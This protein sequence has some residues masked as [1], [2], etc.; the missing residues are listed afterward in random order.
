[1]TYSAGQ[2][3]G[4]MPSRTGPTLLIVF[5]AL[6]MV[7]APIIA[8]FVAAG[9][10]LSQIDFN[11]I[12]TMETIPNPGTTSVL[13]P[14]TYS[15][16]PDSSGMPTDLTCTVMGP[17]GVA[18]PTDS[19]YGAIVTF[20]ATTAQAYSVE[21]S[22]GSTISVMDGSFMSL[23]LDNIPLFGGLVLGGLVL[24]FLG[25]CML[26]G[27]IIWNVS[28]GRRRREIMNSGFGGGYGGYGGY[29]GPPSGAYGGPVHNPYSGQG[30]A[31]GGEGYDPYAAPPPH[32]APQ[33]PNPYGQRPDEP[34]RYGERIDPYR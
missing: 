3:S 6:G 27:G 12:E 13:H 24:G 32:G 17:D 22:G 10:L 28:V 25:F 34:P 20:E 19:V 7:L 9:M 30:H 11:A 23:V 8:I 33:Q 15:L 14:G 1:M 4:K 29:G 2:Y 18:V 5:G 21:C 31:M 16:L 26:I